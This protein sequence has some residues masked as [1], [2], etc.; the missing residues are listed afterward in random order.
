MSRWRWFDGGWR[1]GGCGFRDEEGFE[2]CLGTEVRVW[3]LSES[4]MVFW[5]WRWWLWDCTAIW[6]NGGWRGF[7][8]FDGG[9]RKGWARFV[10]W[11]R[12]WWMCDVGSGEGFVVVS[13]WGSSAKERW[14]WRRFLWVNSVGLWD[15][16]EVW[17][18]CDVEG[19]GGVVKMEA[20]WL[21]VRWGFRR[22]VREERKRICGFL[23]GYWEFLSEWIV[24]GGE[25]FIC[26]ESVRDEG[27]MW[28]RFSFC[29]LL[30]GFLERRVDAESFLENE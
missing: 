20:R 21:E 9:A 24:S 29:F 22:S 5:R 19:G 18:S 16:G 15:D 3:R 4:A 8:R 1:F 30:S 27:A 7:R 12:W 14:R 26:A 11:W 10:G 13:L 23:W 28:V 2:W 25:S 17:V 6:V